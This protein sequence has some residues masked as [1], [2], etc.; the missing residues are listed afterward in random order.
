MRVLLSIFAF[1]V[2]I[3]S[4]AQLVANGNSGTSTTVYTNGSSNNT[5]YIWC[6]T[7]LGAQNG[8]FTATP[9]SGTGPYTFNWFF[10]DQTNGSWTPLSTS[11]GA[12]STM[13]NLASDGYRV[14]IRDVTNA[15]TDCF[16]AWVWNLNTAV[17]ASNS[18][19][20]C[21]DISLSSTVNATSS[22]SYYNPPPPESLITPATQISVCFTAT[23]TWVSDLAFYLVG[24][25]ACGSPAV[26]LSANPGSIGQGAV[27]NSGNN[28]TNLCFTTSSVANLNVC[29]PAPATLSGT[30]G[31]YGPAPIAINWAAVNGCNAAEGGWRVQVFDCIGGDVG[32]LTNAVISFSGL[33][34]L[35]GS[36]TTITYNSG[37]IASTILDNSCSAGT[38]SIFT[39]PLPVG[40]TTPITINATTALQWTSNPGTTI[41][42]STLTNATAPNVLP[43]TTDFT[44]TATTSFGATSCIS[45]AMTSVSYTLPI[46]DA[47][48]DQ[49]ICTGNVTLTGAGVGV[50]TSAWDN[51]VTNGVAFAPGATTT[52]TLTGT[53]ANGCTDTD[54]VTITVAPSIV[55][56]AGADVAVCAG[57]SVTL[58]GTGANTYTWNNGAADGVSFIPVANTTY[59]VTGT[60][61]LGCTGTDQ[62]NVTVNLIPVVSAG[63]DQSIC[64]GGAVTLTGGGATTYSWDNGVTDNVSFNPA[65]PLTYTVTGTG[66]GGC[67]NTD[68]VSVGINSL[69]IVSAGA[70]QTICTGNVTLAGSGASTYTWDNG[71]TDNVAFAPG[72]TT[73]YTVTGTDL[74]GCVNTDQVTVTIAPNIVVGA[75]ID[76]AVCTGGTVTLSGSGANTYVWDNGATNGVAFVPVANATYTV[77]GT[78]LLGCTGTDQINV[79]VNLIPVVTAGADQSVCAGGSVTLT[80][81]GATSYSWNNGITDNVAF[82]PAGTLTYTVTGTG[83]GGCTNTDQVVVS[84]LAAP[85]VTAGANQTV[86]IGTNVTLNGGGAA[87]YT[88]SN[89]VTNGVAFVPAVGPV[90]YTVTGTAANTC[91]NTATV[92]VLVNALPAVTAGANQSVCIGAN[93][94]L[95]GGGAASYSWSNG[96]TNGVAFTPAVGSITYTVTGTAATTCV[97]T[98]TVTVLVNA[99]PVVGAG[100]NQ[101]VCAGANVTLNGSGAASYTWNNGV[102]NGVA[103]PAPGAT[104]IY[105]VTGTS[106]AGCINTANMTVT[107]NANPVVG[108]GVDQTICP[109]ATATLNG[110]G[111]ATYVWNNGVTN[112]AAF[113]PVATVTYTVTG[114]AVNGCTATDQVIVNISPLPAI[115]AG[116]DF[117]VCQGATITLSGTGGSNYVWT[118]GAVNAVGFVQAPGSTTYTVTGSNALGCT[119]T[120][121]ITVIVV[122]NPSAN[123]SSTSAI[124]GTA[125][126]IVVF[127]NASLNASNYTWN[128]GNGTTTTSSNLSSQTGVFSAVGTYTVLLTAISGPCTSTDF[129]TVTVIPFP[130]AEITLPNVFTPNEDGQND[131]FY[132]D[133]KYGAKIEVVVVNRWGNKMIE[134]ND[135]TTKWNGADATDGVYFYTYKVTD[136]NGVETIGQE[137]ITLVRK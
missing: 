17:T 37:A 82:N 122:T 28:V 66:V 19:A 51:G 129:M 59:T 57:G 64:P 87:S 124:S 48:L 25:A 74:S 30:Y 133:V 13:I 21:D 69:P 24:P 95:N 3:T 123:I 137:A 83:V 54:Q 102:T 16:I 117:T 27:C 39:V 132:L 101:A 32:V 26:L 108:A 58:T 84:I 125:D 86:C 44:L 92:T 47:G 77:T 113:S 1:F 55:V 53:A 96:V 68:Q 56:G 33:A 104:T 2:C 131:F 4:N 35:C 103:F 46:A 79:V 135:F 115:G 14:E 65:A 36:P 8:N 85:V 106:A 76:V 34:S 10:H 130:P 109:G 80:G 72:V 15:V 99:L 93:V 127:D 73:T 29:A 67:T 88:W 22:F 128:F 61:L 71:V 49:T 75:G 110:S 118:N 120:D 100:I 20:T 119:N 11:V 90:T 9:T 121:Q 105:T 52:Y 40:L 62:I 43:G 50:V 6:S 94:T 12:T 42:N 41:N 112:N 78:D 136:K 116:A 81:G 23:H 31:T 5:I 126:L 114:T 111:A 91:T 70:D 63:A 60:D 97:N 89:G 38:A 45:T 107:I 134:I 18:I 7:V 98:A